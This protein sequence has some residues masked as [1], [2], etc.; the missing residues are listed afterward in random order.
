M[1]DSAFAAQHPSAS[2]T[3]A[4]HVGKHSITYTLSRYL[5]CLIPLRLEK[6]KK[7]GLTH[8]GY[9]NGRQNV[10][11]IPPS[12]PAGAEVLNRL[13]RICVCR[14]MALDPALS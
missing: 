3:F 12:L 1:R 5:F 4:V 6:K 9:I 11:R 14:F 10:G 7:T 13:Y 8:S 2:G